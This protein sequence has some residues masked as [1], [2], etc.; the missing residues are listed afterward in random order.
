MQRE[1]M[2]IVPQGEVHPPVTVAV[3][4]IPAATV[5]ELYSNLINHIHDSRPDED[6]APLEKAYR[7]AADRHKGPEA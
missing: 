5:E 4:S 3:P 6:L 2:A 7:F 1:S